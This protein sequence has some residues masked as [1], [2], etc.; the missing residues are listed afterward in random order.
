M[1]LTIKKVESPSSALASPESWSLQRSGFKEA[2][3]EP[4]AQAQ[5]RPPLMSYDD[6]TRAQVFI[7]V[8]SMKKH[9]TVSRKCNI[10]K[11]EGH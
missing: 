8:R 4:A 10:Q 3:R 7:F 5:S 1:R 6:M 2:W 11:N 9:L